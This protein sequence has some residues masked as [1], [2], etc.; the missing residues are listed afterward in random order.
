MNYARQLIMETAK[1]LHSFGYTVYVS[2]SGTHG[3][4]TDGTRAVSF[5]ESYGMLHVSGNY[6]P[7]K[8]SGTGWVIADAI[9]AINEDQ[10]KKYITENAPS[11]AGNTNPRYTTPEQHLKTYG[12]SSGYAQFQPVTL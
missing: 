5:G 8:R 12:D 7:S 10:A 1:A 3:F 11:W 4:Y 6:V 2:K 9:G